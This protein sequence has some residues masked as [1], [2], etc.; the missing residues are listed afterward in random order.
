MKLASLLVAST[1]CWVLAASEALAITKDWGIH[2]PVETDAGFVYNGSGSSPLSFTD[3]FKFT[4]LGLTDLSVGVLGAGFSSATAGLFSGTPGS[5]IQIGASFG[6]GLSFHPF[7]S[8][9]AGSYYYEVSGVVDPGKTGIYNIQSYAS[10]PASVPEP[11]PFW[12][13]AGGLL[14]FVLTYEWRQRHQ[15]EMQ[16]G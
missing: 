6:M 12:L 15:A 2:D 10:A 7:S 14:L 3:D 8:L 1:L 13:L 4:L 16:V 5:G 9:G 11:S